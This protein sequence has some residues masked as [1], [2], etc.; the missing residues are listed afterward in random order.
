MEEEVGVVDVS[1]S[2]LER[3]ARQ[4]EEQVKLPQSVSP[5][6]HSGSTKTVLCTLCTTRSSCTPEMEKVIVYAPDLEVS[7][8]Q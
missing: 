1:S 4:M 2:P 3:L 6:S 5:G 8:P 7:I